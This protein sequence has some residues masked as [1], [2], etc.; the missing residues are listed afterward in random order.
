VNERLET[1][2]RRVRPP[3]FPVAVCGHRGSS[4]RAPENTLA[5]F[6]EAITDGCDLVELD[7]LVTR[8][9]ELVVLHDEKLGRTTDGK[10]V[11]ASLTLAE[12]RRCDAGAWFGDGWKGERVPHLCEALGTI[13]R[14]AVPMIELKQKAAKVPALVP[15]LAALIRAHGYA[16]RAVVI[17][18]DDG[19]ARAVRESLPDVLVARIAF[20]RLG[21][22]RAA[23]NRFDGVV[24]WRASATRRFLAEARAA[25]VFVAPWTVNRPADMEFFARH[26]CDVVITDHPGALRERLAERRRAFAEAAAGAV[27]EATSPAPPPADAP[28]APAAPAPAEPA[29]ASAEPAGAALLEMDPAPKGEPASGAEAPAA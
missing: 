28:E 15:S 1:L 17:A 4:G 27:E 7:V 23:K 21:I 18:W 3:E 5:A 26:A 22:R 8:D 2:L 10:G 14:K 16:D 29:P 25:G 13:E 6:R 20:T 11:V 12:V 24:P 19:T 9:H